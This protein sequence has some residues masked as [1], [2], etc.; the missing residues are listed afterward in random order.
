MDDNKL[1]NEAYYE[2]LHKEDIHDDF[3]R[4]FNAWWALIPDYKRPVEHIGMI[5]SAF[6]GGYNAGMLAQKRSFGHD[7]MRAAGI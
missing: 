1:L 7:K 5:R 4:E 2:Q 6:S 3:E